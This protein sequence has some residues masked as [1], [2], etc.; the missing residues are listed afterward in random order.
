MSARAIFPSDPKY[1]EVVNFQIFAK[2]LPKDKQINVCMQQVSFANLL[3]KESCGLGW[4]HS[5]RCVPIKGNDNSI[6]FCCRPE[7]ANAVSLVQQVPET[8]WLLSFFV[9]VREEPVKE[10]DKPREF[11]PRDTWG[12]FLEVHEGQLT[13]RYEKMERPLVVFSR[14]VED[15]YKSYLRYID[16]DVAFKNLPDLNLGALKRAFNDFEE[17]FKEFD[18]M[19]V[20]ELKRQYADFTLEEMTPPLQRRKDLI[21][22]AM[23]IMNQIER[24]SKKRTPVEETTSPKRARITP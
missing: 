2:D 5:K 1:L 17:V 9:D 19:D 24:V 15:F 10:V 4:D 8:N 12:V 18:K 22:L 23:E 6:V 11:K 3:I 16:R 13:A 20:K 21:R 14:L 7:N